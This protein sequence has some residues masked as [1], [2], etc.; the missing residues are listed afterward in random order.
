MTNKIDRFVYWAPR[1]LAV[2][3]VAF[4]ALFSLDV[5][6][7]GKSA[8][9]IATGLFVH[10]VPVLLLAAVVAIS[11]KRE[12]VGGITF[13]LAGIFYIMMVMAGALKN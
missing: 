10:N 3:F 1:V 4:L 5:F 11:W 12:I 7:S 6:E 8:A 2:C 13:I 9:E